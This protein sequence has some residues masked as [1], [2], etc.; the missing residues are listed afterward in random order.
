MNADMA[1]AMLDRALEAEIGIGIAI[2][3]EDRKWYTSLFHKVKQDLR[4][5]RLDI[6]T[7]IHPAREPAEIWIV[8]KSVELDP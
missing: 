2:L 1:R 7:V 3:E 6:L 5:P 4:D 8:K